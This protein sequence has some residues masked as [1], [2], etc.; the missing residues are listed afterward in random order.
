MVYAVAP[1]YP[2]VGGGIT[3]GYE[4]L[5]AELARARSG[6]VA[7][8]GPAA[9]RWD[10]FS[11]RL[12]VAV[13]DRGPRVR[14]LDARHQLRP[15][16]EIE[17]RT[18]T[19]TL[20]GD[21]VFATQY[22]GTIADL[23]GP[24]GI[25]V[26]SDDT[27]L[28]I[29]YGPG[30]ALAAHDLL[31]YVDLPKAL[32][33]RAMERGEATNLGQGPGAAGTVRR[34]LFIDWPM[35]DRHRRA[36]SGRWARYVDLSDPNEPRSLDA[37]DLRRAVR[38]ITSGPFR[39]RPTFLAQPWGG[40][41][42]RET[43]GAHDGQNSG[44]GY[45]LIAPES[46]VLLGTDPPMEVGLD[47][48]IADDPASLLGDHVTAR[49]GAAFP[50]RF[51]YLDTVGGGDLSVHCH[52]REEYMRTVFGLPYTQHE[53]Y[54][55]MV[56]RPGARIFLGLR[57]DVDPERFRAAADRSQALGEPFE[58][59]RFVATFP[60]RRHQL[61]LIPAGTPHGSGEGNVVLEISATPYLYSLR[62]YDWLRED[63]RGGFR[64]VQLD[65]AFANLSPDRRGEALRRLVPESVVVRQASGSVEYDLGGHPDLF[66]RVRRLEFA[67]A[68]ADAT[69]GRFHV[70][71]LVE[72]EEVV[73]R[74]ESGRE[75]PLAYAETLVVPA[76]VGR[77][78]IVRV[79]GGPPKV[80][81]AFVA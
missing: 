16:G 44:L 51:D 65:H 60:A 9:V 55:V 59:E 14:F 1:R 20:R 34:L 36:L 80:V 54:Y 33:L 23:F 13:A 77:Y 76:K 61:Y 72:G 48:L 11:R 57:D 7:I 81:K 69:D 18:E 38:A 53:T 17:S 22:G 75:H 6:V 56:T 2:V 4:A 46:G 8:D 71:N 68:I 73:V 24:Q 78:E 19:A 40:R 52:P 66:F 64:A 47:V 41:W 45:E 67:S 29:V 10:D 70:L 32:A 63:L 58:I 62:F 79:S 42:L 26:A 15:W 5:A 39:A 31:W 37:A 28:T 74:T 43:L 21:P 3:R 27:T 30:S 49:F 35:E 50:I 12:A 25:P